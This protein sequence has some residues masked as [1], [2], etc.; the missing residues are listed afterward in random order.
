M[1]IPTDAEGQAIVWSFL[2]ACGAVIVIGAASTFL[3]WR[4]KRNSK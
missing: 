4:D 1:H 3:N 2:I